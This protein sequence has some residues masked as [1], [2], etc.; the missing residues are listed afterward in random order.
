MK[1]ALTTNRDIT[2]QNK[3]ATLV[4]ACLFSNVC[5]D[6]LVLINKIL[7][8]LSDNELPQEFQKSIS[9]ASKLVNLT[10][11]STH[12]MTKLFTKCSTHLK[13]GATRIAHNESQSIKRAIKNG[14]V[15]MLKTRL[16][17]YNTTILSSHS[18]IFEAEISIH[19]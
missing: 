6:S 11:N 10:L 4:E 15:S 16:H 5:V 12:T 2:Q 1:D 3:A 13:C 9:D 14:E 8:S 7:S 17:H 19:H 18:T